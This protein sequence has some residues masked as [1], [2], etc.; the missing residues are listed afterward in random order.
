MTNR[1]TEKI[2]ERLVRDLPPRMI[3]IGYERRTCIL[4]ARIAIDALRTLG[5]KANPL[6]VRVQVFNA[7]YVA[8][9]NR[10]GRML[11]HGDTLDEKAW[12]IGIGYGA[13]P[14]ATAPG[15]DGHVLVIVDGRWA[16]DLTIDQANRPQYGIELSPHYWQPSPGFLLGD[17]PEVFEAGESIVRYEAMPEERGYLRAGDWTNARRYESAGVVPTRELISELQAVAA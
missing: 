13:N 4:H 14:A 10:I 3:A 5:I 8:Q 1:Q 12:T 17:L 6:A 16:V 11:T 7:E 9:V 15:Y 2:I